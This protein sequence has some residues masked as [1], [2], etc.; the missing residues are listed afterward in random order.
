[1]S[2]YGDVVTLK[3]GRDDQDK[4]KD[5][6]TG[7]DQGTKRRKPSKDA[8]PSK[9][10]KSKDSRT[11]GLSK[12]NEPQPKSS[13][14]ST[15]AEELVFEA[16]DT[17]MQYD[18]WNE[19]GHLDDQPDD[20]SAPSND[21][22][23]KPEK[24]PTPD[25][26]WNK[27]KAIDSRPQTWINNIAK[28]R[29]PPCMFNELL[30]TPIDFSA[31]VMNNLKIDN[32]TQEILKYVTSTIRTK[33]ARYDNIEGIEDLVQT[34]WNPMKKSSHDVYSKRRIIMVTRVK[35]M[36]WFDYGYLK[37]IKVRRDDNVLYTFKEDALSFRSDILNM[38]PYT[39]YK[40]HQGI[41]YQDKFQRNRLMRLNELYKFCDGML[42]S[43][44][45][46][47]N[48]IASNLEMD[49]LPKRH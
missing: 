26:P 39:E 36:K 28:T 2:S 1:M 49:Y 9:G 37:K 33:A 22:F 41:I 5:P 31:Y 45:T 16:A 14:K 17:E 23:K 38:I 42:S 7:S 20:E 30:S 35:V 34:L 21:W 3:R 4:D 15:Q 44:R 43:V 32:L 24:P 12:G 48:D 18:Q 40:N 47:L 8:E 11:S 10:S 19:F 46:V 29:Q 6:S 27:G 25:R 13:G